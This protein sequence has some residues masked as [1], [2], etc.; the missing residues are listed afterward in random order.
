[1]IHKYYLKDQSGFD[2]GDLKKMTK[3]VHSYET[4]CSLY[5]G[6]NNKKNDA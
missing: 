3:I 2:S 6:N 5:N 4:R 1:M